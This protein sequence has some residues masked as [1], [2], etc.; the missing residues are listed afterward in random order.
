[1]PL[2]YAAPAARFANVRSVVHTKHG[3]NVY[4]RRS[5][6]LAKTSTRFVT[7]FVCV[8]DETA[9]AAREKER[10]NEST[11]SV[12]PNGIPL[13]DFGADP[14]ARA[15]IRREFGI[16]D[17]AL[18]IGA[19]GRL[20]PEKNYAMLV[21]AASPLLSESTRLVLVGDG[22]GRAAIEAAIPPDKSRFITLAGARRDVPDLFASFDLFA[23]SSK[24]EGL[25]LVIP[26]AMASFLPIVST[27]VGGLPGIVPNDV[28]IL[29]PPN[30]ESAFRSALQ[31]LL[32]N[33]EKRASFAKAARSYALSRFSL[34]RM[35]DAYELLYRG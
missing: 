25:P 29:V 33:P 30:D 13:D 15:R 3:A 5:M 35:A 18:V 11:L 20:V 23:L 1:L 26:E 10:P 22:E 16:A 4:G 12:I 34:D 2:I 14:I 7:R 21:R 9:Q 17:D 32:G 24:T 28:G 19:V 8:S 27:A 31:T 6:F